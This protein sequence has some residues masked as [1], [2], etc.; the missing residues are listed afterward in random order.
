VNEKSS[1]E[2]E[3]VEMICSSKEVREGL[4]DTEGR[5]D[6]EGINRIINREKSILLEQING[7]YDMR[8][9]LWQHVRLLIAHFYDGARAE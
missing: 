2:K 3:L 5:V 7:K 1:K 8:I 6:E 4:E 9:R